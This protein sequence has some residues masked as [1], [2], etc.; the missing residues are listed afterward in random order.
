MTSGR[1]AGWDTELLTLVS[2]N[3]CV[4]LQHPPLPRA[5]L[6]HTGVRRPTQ[7]QCLVSLCPPFLSNTFLEY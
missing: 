2:V 5:R 6:A 1:T 7:K 4:C 3:G